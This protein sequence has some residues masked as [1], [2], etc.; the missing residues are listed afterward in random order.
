MK[1]W[2]KGSECVGED[3]SYPTN[4]LLHL[5]SEL[6]SNFISQETDSNM[7]TDVEVMDHGL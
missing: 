2:G 7:K 3:L 4:L 6:K 1:R 5:A